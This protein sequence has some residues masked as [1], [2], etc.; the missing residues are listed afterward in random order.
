VDEAEMDTIAATGTII[1]HNPESNM[2]NAV[3]VTQVLKD[4]GKGHSGRSRL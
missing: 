1:V 2:N 4:A 3:G